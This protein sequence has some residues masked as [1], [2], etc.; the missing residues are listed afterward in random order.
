V[1][2]DPLN[3]EGLQSTT[4]SMCDVCYCEAGGEAVNE[5]GR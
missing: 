1:V 3:E 4:I 5:D 2:D